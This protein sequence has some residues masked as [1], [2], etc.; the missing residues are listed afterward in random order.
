M[1]DPHHLGA[2]AASRLCGG[3]LHVQHHRVAFHLMKKNKKAVGEMC[4]A[5]LGNVKV[6][7]YVKYDARMIASHI[8]PRKVRYLPAVISNTWHCIGKET[9]YR[10]KPTPFEPFTCIL[11]IAL[12]K[13]LPGPPSDWPAPHRTHCWLKGSRY[14]SL[15]LLKLGFTCF[16]L[17]LYTFYTIRGSSRITV[18]SGT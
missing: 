17:Q 18:I 4:R 15:C 5:K 6:R 12:G 11:H 16:W 3:T 10:Y 2:E 9:K 8:N 13:R 7:I 14:T 1:K